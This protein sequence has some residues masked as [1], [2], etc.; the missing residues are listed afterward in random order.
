MMNADEKQFKLLLFLEDYSTDKV[1]VNFK[2][3]YFVQKSV[4]EALFKKYNIF[5]KQITG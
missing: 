2:N 4:C 3:K 1:F 5:L